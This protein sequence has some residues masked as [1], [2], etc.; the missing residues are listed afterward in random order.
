MLP[1]LFEESPLSSG[2]PPI[3][4]TA[5]SGQ[6]A[7][8]DDAVSPIQSRLSVIL[9][10]S[11]FPAL[12]QQIIETISALDDDASS[13]Q[14]LANVVLREYSLTLAVVRTAN[15]AHYRRTGRPIQSATHAMMMLG[16]RTVRHLASS[17]LLFE[18]YSRRSPQ[19]KEL[20]LMSLLTANQA[21]D[22]ATRLGVG[23]PEEA[24]LCGMF[25]NL[26]EVLV[27]CHFPDDYTSIQTA[28]A[29]RRL[30]PTGAANAVLGF[31]YEELG[32]ALAKHWGMPESVMTTM[33][34]RALS[35]LSEL[36]GIISF[37]HDLTRAIYRSDNTNTDSKQAVDEVL[38]LY[39]PRLKFSRATAVE[40]VESALAETRELFGA[41][42][43]Q[44]STLRDLTI[45]ARTALG[46]RVLNTGEWDATTMAGN[47]A[48][49]L[50][51]LREKLRQELENKIDPS[52]DTT[53]GNV[54]L[55][56][57]EAAVRGG[58]FDR[59]IVCVLNA[60]RT[61]LTARAALGIGAE[62]LIPKFDFPMNTRGGPVPAALLQRHPVYLPCD[63]AFTES[64]VRWAK[65]MGCAQF[66]V[67]PIIVALKLVGC[68]Y[69][70]RVSAQPRPDRPTITY[71]KSL[72]DLV[73]HAIGAR[74]GASGASNRTENSD[75]TP[76][77][78][79]PTGGASTRSQT[80]SF[81]THA[82]EVALSQTAEHQV[83]AEWKASLEVS[84]AERRELTAESRAALVLRL[85]QGADV[86]AI[87]ASAGVAVDQLEQWKGEF[88][89]GALSRM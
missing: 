46:E 23:D 47:A 44:G 12:S 81:D 53:L 59:A 37:S 58:P 77:G 20:M 71:I 5:Q 40:I 16:A 21:R 27:A 67:F 42:A 35:P 85:L 61:Q 76:A 48:D 7:R 52:S 41:S 13:L 68:I 83:P 6:P 19:L 11:D 38:A 64:D 15:S 30:T 70:D 31:R 1:R 82:S 74:R 72:C 57:L 87:A 14:R 32:I 50:L 80:A 51:A 43:Q 56:A 78:G 63:R 66:G 28:V 33:A 2:R 73:S 39:A 65:G 54:L 22:T 55:L 8:A 29:E 79:T 3:I 25:R 4:R 34:S 49:A 10:G 24:H 69:V 45:A 17:L 86:T 60:D 18:N 36:G 89:A 9:G 75:A 62:E 26:G 84:L 88:L